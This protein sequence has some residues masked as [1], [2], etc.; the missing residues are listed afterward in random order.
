MPKSAPTSN[1]STVKALLLK[2]REQERAKKSRQP[3]AAANGRHNEVS[4]TDHLPVSNKQALGSSPSQFGKAGA[5]AAKTIEVAAPPVMKAKKPES[6]GAE[7]APMDESTMLDAYWASYGDAATRA[8]LRSTNHNKIMEVVIGTDDRTQISDTT[9]YP[10]RCIASL[11][12]TAQDGTGWIGTGWLVGPRLLLTA[13]HC[14]YMSDHGGWVQQ[15]EVIP[16]RQGD[17]FPYQS[18]IA[19]EFRSVHGWIDDGK[20]EFD[21]GAILLPEANRYGDQLGWFGFQVR[22][23]D[24]LNNLTVNISGYPGDKPSGTQWY[25]SGPIKNVSDRNFTYDID[26]AGGQSGAPVWVYQND[27]SR[28]GVGVHTNGAMGGNSATRITQE[29]YDNI[30]AWRNEVP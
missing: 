17:T 18:C 7:A 6:A 26:T 25:L 19:T 8:M 3:S 24:D 28:L 27:G 2:E 29:V 10:L 13:G 4:P 1:E 30:T 20:S 12:I 22:S 9:V 14:V 15:M 5:P 11:R 16:G 21:Y 23:D